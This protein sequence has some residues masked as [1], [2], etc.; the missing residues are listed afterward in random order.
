MDEFVDLTEDSLL[1]APNTVVKLI[2][3]TFIKFLL[4][5][6]NFFSPHEQVNLHGR[7]GAANS[8]SLS[9]LQCPETLPI[10]E[11]PDTQPLEG[12]PDTQPMEEQGST[13][14]KPNVTNDGHLCRGSGENN[15]EEDGSDEPLLIVVDEE[16][17]LPIIEEHAEQSGSFAAEVKRNCP[18]V[19]LTSAMELSAIAAANVPEVSR[20][21][22]MAD[23]MASKIEYD[24]LR[25]S[26]QFV[27]SRPLN[28]AEEADSKLL[29]SVVSPTK[30]IRSW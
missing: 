3:S 19:K 30:R 20:T 12:C 13:S 25:A 5:H 1:E 23:V 22:V 10:D 18:F 26:P 21:Q 15:D 9:V 17:T 27:K 7:Q 29:A 6:L 8:S 2:L 24:R 16:N 11:F 4:P 28:A 14:S